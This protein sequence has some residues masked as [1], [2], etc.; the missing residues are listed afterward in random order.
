MHA[1]VFLVIQYY[2]A[3]HAACIGSRQVASVRKAAGGGTC[4][5]CR[6]SCDH[7]I[8]VTAQP[9]DDLR[10]QPVAMFWACPA[11]PW[12]PGASVSNRRSTGRAS[13][14]VK[15][16]AL[17]VM[18]TMCR[19]AMACDSCTMRSCSAAGSVRTRSLCNAWPHRLDH[20]CPFVCE[21]PSAEGNSGAGHRPARAN[22]AHM[23]MR[24]SCG[25]GDVSATRCPRCVPCWSTLLRRLEVPC[26]TE[27]RAH[28]S[29][30]FVTAGRRSSEAH[31]SGNH[32]LK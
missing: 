24:D 4:V 7:R 22:R 18:L 32:W 16:T 5:R 6:Y 14:S 28:S 27:P 23:R 26:T 10:L 31:R 12:G 25:C 29:V 3:Q 15:G 30:G 11:C 19:L 17:Q 21:R 9:K 8:E 1:G 2:Y 13:R 20:A